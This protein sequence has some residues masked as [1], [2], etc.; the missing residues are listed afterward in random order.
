VITETCCCGATFHTDEQLGYA[1]RAAAAF[2]ANHRHEVPEPAV[3]DGGQAPQDETRVPPRTAGGDRIRAY[4]A[5]RG[6][7]VPRIHPA[8]ADGGQA[9]HHD[10][11]EAFICHSCGHDGCE[12]GQA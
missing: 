3:G 8:A 4:Y 2:R 9:H 1:E 6:E 5:E 11:S 10:Y 12:M 7:E